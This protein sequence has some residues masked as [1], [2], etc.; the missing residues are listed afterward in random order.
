MNGTAPVKCARTD[1]LTLPV[2]LDY[3]CL[4]KEDLGHLAYQS[5]PVQLPKIS[6]WP[7]LSSLSRL[8]WLRRFEYV[9]ASPEPLSDE[10]KALMDEQGVDF[11]TSGLKYLTNDARVSQS[12]LSLKHSVSAGVVKLSTCPALALPG[13][14]CGMSL[15]CMQLSALNEGNQ[16]RRTKRCSM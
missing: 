8:L 15:F 13:V 9:P 16:A 14:L 12:S 4:H 10:V 1:H 6:C 2:M 5:F 11:E 7:R 3:I